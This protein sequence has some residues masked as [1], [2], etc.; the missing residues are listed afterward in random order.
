MNFSAWLYKIA[1]NAI[2][3]HLRKVYRTPD[4]QE[5]DDSLPVYHTDSTPENLDKNMVLQEVR[6]AFEFLPI[7]YKQILELRYIQDLTIEEVCEITGKS[8]LAVRLAQHRALKH[9][10]KIIGKTHG[11]GH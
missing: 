6:K 3:D 4:I 7:Q 5:L 9:L 8:N 11:N 1:Q 2:N 10:R